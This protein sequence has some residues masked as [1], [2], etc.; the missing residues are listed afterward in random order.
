[1]RGAGRPPTPSSKCSTFSRYLQWQSLI[2]NGWIEQWKEQDWSN[3]RLREQI[4]SFHKTR[5]PLKKELKENRRIKFH[6]AV[7]HSAWPSGPLTSV[8]SPRVCKALG[9]ASWR[10]TGQ[11]SGSPLQWKAEH[12]QGK[13]TARRPCKQDQADQKHPWSE[14]LWA[15]NPD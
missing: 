11:K 12:V 1:M 8:L 9:W 10:I 7:V 6:A 2:K 13:R 14:C 5:Y 3:S 15:D 4:I